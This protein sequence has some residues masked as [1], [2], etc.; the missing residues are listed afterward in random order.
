MELR[1]NVIN[2]NI[3]KVSNEYVVAGSRNYLKAVFSFSTEEWNGLRKI[4]VFKHGETVINVLLEDDCCMVP[5]EVI[6]QD[7]FLVSVYGGDLITADAAV[8]TVHESGYL[9]GKD[10]GTHAQEVHHKLFEDIERLEK[11]KVSVEKLKEEFENYETA[12]QEKDPTVPDWAKQ[13]DKPTYTPE[14]IGAVSED[15]AISL[16]ELDE[17]FQSI[18]NE[19]GN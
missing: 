14:D 9:E 3:F 12:H 16:V 6:G 1:F 18:F 11:E 4:A 13:P 17:M 5:W 15:A 2:Q 10:G 8:V 7:K 19:G